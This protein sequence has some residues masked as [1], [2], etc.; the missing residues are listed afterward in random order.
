[1]N[2][3]VRIASMVGLVAVALLA[4]LPW[5]DRVAVEHVEDGFRR[6]LIAHA[7]ARALNAGI[8]LLQETTVAVSVLGTGVTVAL[9]QVLDPLN[10]LVEWFASMTLLD[11]VLRCAAGAGGHRGILA[12]GAGVDRSGGVGCGCGLAGQG[13]APRPAPGADR[14]AAGAVCG[15]S[16]G[17]RE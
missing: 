9:G 15:S 17:D 2:R 1:M 7:T 16:V 8:S 14:A 5:L 4:W 6:A 10:D 12:A 3:N 11:G 13:L